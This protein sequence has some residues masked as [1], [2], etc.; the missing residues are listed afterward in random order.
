MPAIS[1]IHHSSRV[2]KLAAYAN[3]KDACSACYGSL[4]YALDRL[5]DEG[6]LRGKKTNSI[7]IGQGYRG[8]TGKTGVGQCTKCFEKTLGGCPPKAVEIVEFLRKEWN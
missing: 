7:A 4:I 3:P 2:S 8:K 1:K 5:N 6:R